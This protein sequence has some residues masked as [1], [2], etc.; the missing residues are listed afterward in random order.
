M[1]SEKYNIFN[2]ETMQ[3]TYSLT[4]AEIKSTITKIPVHHYNWDQEKLMKTKTKES[5]LLFH[6]NFIRK[7]PTLILLCSFFFTCFFLPPSTDKAN[8]DEVEDFKMEINF[9]KTI[10]HHE[11]VVTML[12]CCTLYPPLCLVVECVP[13]G[14]L[15]HYLRDLRK[16]VTRTWI[17]HFLETKSTGTRK[18]YVLFWVFCWSTIS[19]I[20]EVFWPC[21]KP[22][23]TISSRS[24][25]FIFIGLDIPLLTTLTR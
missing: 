22:Q 20:Q 21:N 23:L 6:T 4:R 14:D 3:C 10:G 18:E 17:S 1:I 2:R 12:G 5:P 15:L 16:T 24:R 25:W 9:M 11:N 13:H 8:E 7:T 19:E